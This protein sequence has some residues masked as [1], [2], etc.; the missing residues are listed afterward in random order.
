VERNYSD[1][2]ST[3]APRNAAV[4]DGQPPTVPGGAPQWRARLGPGW[5]SAVVTWGAAPVPRLVVE[6]VEDGV[7]VKPRLA[8][9]RTVVP[10]I[11]WRWSELAAVETVGRTGLRFVPR[12]GSDYR[13]SLAHRRRTAL[14]A[15]LT[16]H[17]VPVRPAAS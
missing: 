3:N 17:G 2:R 15:R 10:G 11:G 13:V 7:V 1:E 4:T 16:A 14:V 6:V 9:L 12:Q 5:L 8:A